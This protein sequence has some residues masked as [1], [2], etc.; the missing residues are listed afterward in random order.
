[1]S[2]IE[3]KI[4]HWKH[5]KVNVEFEEIESV[6]AHVIP[7]NWSFHNSHIKITHPSLVNY[8]HCN[9]HGDF[10]INLHHNQG[11]FKDILHLVDV[12]DHIRKN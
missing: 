5:T 1:M 2:K 4:E 7:D 9:Q 6:L 10:F 12:I 11:E 3:K 8:Q